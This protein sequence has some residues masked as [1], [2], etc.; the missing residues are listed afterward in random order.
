[1]MQPLVLKKEWLVKCNNC[2][3]D[4][5]CDTICSRKEVGYPVDGS[6]EY[7]IEVCKQCRCEACAA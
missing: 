2:G 5:H 1:M 4:S 7:E 6:N 3:C